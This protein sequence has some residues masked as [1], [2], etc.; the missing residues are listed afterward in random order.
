M[1]ESVVPLPTILWQVLLLLV[2]IALES[3]MLHNRLGISRKSSVQ[4]ATSMNLIVTVFGWWA[5]FL[6]NSLLA[7][8]FKNQIIS[9]I[10]FGNILDNQISNFNLVIGSTGIFILFGAFL[11]KLKVLELQEA[12]LKSSKVKTESNGRA[13]LTYRLNQAIIHTDVNRATV[14][15]TANAYSSIVILLLLFMSFLFLNNS[16]GQ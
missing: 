11:V 7:Q 13:G 6:L 10:C 3:R 1:T 4:Y 16:A 12:F 9:Y 8:D 15:F 2:A 5:F 14:V